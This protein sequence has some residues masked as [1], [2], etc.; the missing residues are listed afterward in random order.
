ML[1]VSGGGEMALVGYLC[2][3]VY[4]WGRGLAFDFFGC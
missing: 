2:G 1:F 4:W 3:G